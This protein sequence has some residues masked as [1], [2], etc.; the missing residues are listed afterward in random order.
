M[1]EAYDPADPDAD[2][3][4][5]LSSLRDG[6]ASED[7]DEHGWRKEVRQMI[8]GLLHRRYERW[9]GTPGPPNVITV[10]LTG[11][12]EDVDKG[13]LREVVKGAVEETEFEV[14]KFVSNPKF[15]A[16][17]GAAELA[18]R[19]LFLVKHANVEL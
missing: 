13:G 10:L 8:M 16:A 5:C 6:Q 4:A 7:K 12:P 15:V 11:D 14:D 9:L 2:T 18:W 17:R 3:L 1:R 19:A